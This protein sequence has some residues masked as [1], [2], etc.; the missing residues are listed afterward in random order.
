MKSDSTAIEESSRFLQ[1]F[2]NARARDFVNRLLRHN[3]THGILTHH[4]NIATLNPATIQTN[5]DR[6][7]DEIFH[8]IAA[9]QHHP[10]HLFPALR[11]LSRSARPPS[12]VWFPEFGEAYDHYKHVNKLP[13]RMRQLENLIRGP[14]LCDVGCGGGDWLLYA[15]K[16]H[17]DIQ[18]ATG[19][20]ILDWRSPDAAQEID[21]LQLDFADPK[22]VSPS[23]F[24]SATCLAVLHHVQP[25]RITTF[26]RGVATA[27]RPGGR[28]IVEEDVLLTP[29]DQQHPLLPQERMHAL[30]E[31]QPFFDEYL[32][33]A[34]EHQFP[35]LVL[36]DLLGNSLSVG[37]PD[38]PFPFGFLRLT[39]WIALFST[40]GFQV[41]Q[42]I[43]AGFVTGNF[44]QSAHIFFQ[45][46][47]SA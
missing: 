5:V 28:L 26:L 34:P 38:M 13:R 18:Q 25:D 12:P 19:I 24:D 14:A 44:N 3:Y 21:F 40:C 4:P 23:L 8:T 32:N 35:V 47:R 6:L 37:V 45:M 7:I 27:I 16:N 33:L 17:P 31:H 9:H 22:T 41:Q 1:A 15:R 36:I 46:E 11:A 2:S 10:E 30:R 39:E 20:D 42:I 43:P 29:D